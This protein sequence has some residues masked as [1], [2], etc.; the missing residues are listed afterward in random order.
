MAKTKT[1]KTATNS[2]IV[3]NRVSNGGIYFRQDKSRYI[4]RFTLNGKRI[5]VGSFMTERKAK[6]ALNAARAQ[7]IQA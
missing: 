3:S 4:A 2:K 7:Y 6:Q 1:T 5:N